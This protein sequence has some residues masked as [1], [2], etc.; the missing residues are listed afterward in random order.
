MD[1]DL[2]KRAVE[3]VVRKDK[4]GFNVD[5]ATDIITDRVLDWPTWYYE[6]T[7]GY[8]FYRPALKYQSLAEA[9]KAYKGEGG[10]GALVKVI[11]RYVSDSSAALKAIS[12]RNPA[13]S[14]VAR[15]AEL[16][17]ESGTI[18]QTIIE[19]VLFFPE[20]YEDYIDD[21]Y[22][23][24]LSDQGMIYDEAYSEDYGDADFNGSGIKPYRT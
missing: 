7:E 5:I 22:W 1:E 6:L 18:V 15:A 16:G 13:Y 20:W 10:S 4:G 3:S 21:A 23:S 14:K 24:T 12:E 2:I 11:T 9:L 17:D 8:G 19:L